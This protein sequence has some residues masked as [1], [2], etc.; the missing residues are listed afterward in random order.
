MDIHR[1]TVLSWLSVCASWHRTKNFLTK[2]RLNRRVM[3]ARITRVK[4]TQARGLVMRIQMT[5]ITQV[6]DPVMKT[7]MMNLQ[8]AAPGAT[9]AVRTKTIMTIVMTA[10]EATITVAAAMMIT[11]GAVMMTAATAAAMTLTVAG[12]MTAVPEGVAMMEA[13]EKIS[14]RKC[15]E[16][17]KRSAHFFIACKML[18]NR[19]H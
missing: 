8:V 10:A 15:A 13:K 2:S 17:A 16:T 1:A 19:V 18:K 9:V 5:E 14:E 3:K 12:K 7:Q 11:A 6:P 4:I